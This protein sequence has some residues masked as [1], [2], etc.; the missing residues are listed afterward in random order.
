[1]GFTVVHFL[2]RSNKYKAVTDN[3]EEHFVIKQQQLFLD[4]S[5]YDEYDR[6]FFEVNVTQV[7][8][9]AGDLQVY[10]YL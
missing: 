4:Y 5:S 9:D 8:I 3:I 6:R 7:M 2:N 10:K 1:M